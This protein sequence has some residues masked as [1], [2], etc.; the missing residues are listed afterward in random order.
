MTARAVTLVTRGC[1]IDHKPK[2]MAERK[3]GAGAAGVAIAA[4]HC[5]QVSEID[6]VLK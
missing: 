4:V 1:D 2:Y 3:L 5:A 6:W